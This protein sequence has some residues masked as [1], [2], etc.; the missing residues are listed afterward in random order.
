[1]QGIYADVN[2][3]IYKL[4]LKGLFKILVP[5]L[6]KPV[7]NQIS[8]ILSHYNCTKGHRSLIIHK[9]YVSGLMQI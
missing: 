2:A 5:Q 3:E 1:M 8:I 6:A 7:L 4:T 9:Q